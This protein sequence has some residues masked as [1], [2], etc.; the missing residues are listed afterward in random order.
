MNAGNTPPPQQPSYEVPPEQAGYQSQPGQSGYQVPQGQG[1]YQAPPGQ[2]GYPGQ[3]YGQMP[4]AYP[5]RQGWGSAHKDKWAA[6]ALAFF[7]GM[8]GIHKFYLGY[9][10]EAMIMLIVAIA[11]SLLAGLGMMVMAVISTIEAVQY[12]MLTQEDF[13]R[14]Y[15]YGTKAWL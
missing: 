7:L 12:V 11:G 4:N 3:P 15:V 13:E 6:A 5:V 2:T 14:I 9:K 10:N 8:F 1:G